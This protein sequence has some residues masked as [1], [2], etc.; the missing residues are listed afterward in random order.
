MKKYIIP[1]IIIFIF[2]IQGLFTLKDYGINWDA[3]YNLD[4]GQA[5]IHY[6]TTHKVNYSDIPNCNYLQGSAFISGSILQKKCPT[7]D[8]LNRSIFQSNIYD[9]K[10]TRYIDEKFGGHPPLAGIFDSFG[11]ILFFQYLHVINDNDSYNLFPLF[12]SFIIALVVVLWST[13]VLGVFG[14]SVSA[15][16][17]SLYP[18]LLG[19][20]NFNFKDPPT[21]A[22]YILSVFLF[23]LAIKKRRFYLFIFSAIS[24]GMSFSIKFNTV[25]LPFI[26]IPWLFIVSL[27]K[28]NLQNYKIK[29]ISALLLFPIIS[30]IILCLVWPYA[31]EKP[32]KAIFQTIGFYKSIGT[33]IDYQSTSFLFLGFNTYPLQYILF[34]TPI[35]ILLLT[36]IGLLS[37]YKYAKKDIYAVHFLWMMLFLIPI[38]RIT[39]PGLSSYGGTRQILEFSGGLAL[40]SGLGAVSLCDYL[41][42]KLKYKDTAYFVR[43]I[44]LL[45]FISSTIAVFSLHPNEN[46]YFNAL[47][48]GVKG[49]E[50]KN[51]PGWNDSF[52]N[53][54]FQGI[55]WLNNHAEKNAQLA[56]STQGTDTY[57]PLSKVRSDI[58]I[59]ENYWS[60][61][62]R[63]GEYIIETHL[64]D[65]LSAKYP[66]KFEFASLIPVYT[67]RV[68]SVPVGYVYKND[69]QH[70]KKQFLKNEVT[71]P[72][73]SIASN[74][75][76]TTLLFDQEET[77]TQLQ[78]SYNSSCNEKPNGTVSLLQNSQWE[79][80]SEALGEQF[81][82]LPSFAMG[83]DKNKLIY[84]FP[85]IK[86]KGIKI[87]LFPEQAKCTIMLH[88]FEVKRLD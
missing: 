53:T 39:L 60:G 25:F 71:I 12:S 24:C 51:F 72:I 58:N 36:I 75:L 22:F 43:L 4:R 52:G 9:Y 34:T 64:S 33:G 54:Y 88:N 3:V 50:Q 37:V 86:A 23:W 14:G 16:S 82:T 83:G 49:A 68:D 87:S 63:K 55:I 8:G 20:R 67:I 5:I 10:Y 77:L 28:K 56:Y 61:T 21:A 66:Q 18:L 45:C 59:G 29:T 57:I 41:K 65:A 7:K 44:I 35:L 62:D 69:I 11:N 1:F 42:T 13:E 30:F 70:T 27:W 46:M 76:E 38:L 78:L 15:L 6:V 48:G 81:Y 31:W 80:Q 84:Y 32:L 40:L 73:S 74:E 79:K 19:E 85:Y 17:I 47:I 26:L 2:F